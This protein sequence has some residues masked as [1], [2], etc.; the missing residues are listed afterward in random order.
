MDVYELAELMHTRLCKWDHTDQCPWYYRDKRMGKWTDCSTH[1][2][3]LERARQV[4]ADT[5]MAP[6]Q[7]AKVI[8]AL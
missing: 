7:I 4:I 3:W 6:D 1:K 2:R 5:G 8:E